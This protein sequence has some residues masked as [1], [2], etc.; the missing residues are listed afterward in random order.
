MLFNP[1]LFHAAG[2]NRSNDIRRM[3]NL[4]QVSSPFGRAMETLDRQA[5]SQALYPALL[6]LRAQGQPRDEAAHAVAA[7]AE[8]YA[9][10]CNLDRDPPIGG[11]APA[12]QQHILLQAL[13]EQWP[14]ARLDAALDDKQWR[15]QA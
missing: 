8:G 1:A 5:M 3:A 10:P 12:T 14:P 2:H 6:A 15:Q 4:L 13:D 7:C 9:F 11:M